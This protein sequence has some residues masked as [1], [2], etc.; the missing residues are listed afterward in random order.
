MRLPRLLML[1]IAPGCVLTA[2][3]PAAESIDESLA[4]PEA[5]QYTQTVERE[6]V[7]AVPPQFVESMTQKETGVFLP[8]SA[9]GGEQW[10]GGLTAHVRTGVDA[11]ILLDP[12]EK[13][14]AGVDGITV[15]RR[16]DEED[17]LVEVYGPH[18]SAWVVRYDTDEGEIHL[19]SFSPCIR[20]P[21]DVWRGDKY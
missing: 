1:V 20:L 11:A 4:L 16:E 17:S 19:A 13:H 7:N 9:D 8:C 3:V 2:C 5:K 10:A 14:F 12:V 6:I 15:N 18:R 21:A